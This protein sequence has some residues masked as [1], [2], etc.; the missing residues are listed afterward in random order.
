[1][2]LFEDRED[3]RVTRWY[4]PAPGTEAPEDVELRKGQVL[5]QCWFQGSHSDVGGG[6]AWHG[7]SVSGIM[8]SQGEHR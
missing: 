7:L 1:M 6:K 8:S 5:K 3:F 2:A 4:L